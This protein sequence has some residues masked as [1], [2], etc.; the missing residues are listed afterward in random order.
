MKGFV[1]GVSVGLGLLAAAVGSAAGQAVNACYVPSVGAIYV[2]GLPGAPTACLSPSHT[3]IALGG[4]GMGLPDGSVTTAKLADGAVTT[5]KIAAN[6]VGAGQLATGAV[7]T[8]QLAPAAV[9]SAQLATNAVTSTHLAAGSVDSAQLATGAVSSS[10]LATGAVANADL[11]NNA[12]TVTKIANGAVSQAKLATPVTMATASVGVAGPQTT[13]LTTL[14][15]VTIT[16][17]GPGAVLVI[18]TGYAVQNEAGA[19][20]TVGLGSTATTREYATVTVGGLGANSGEI[21]AFTVMAV[22]PFATG[23]A[24]TIYATGQGFNV[25]NALFLQNEE[26]V[27][28]YF[29]S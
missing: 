23:G 9:T 29:P 8:A 22:V 10:H 27:A 1:R 4:A 21:N 3:P 18:L 7:T 19:S 13:T 2:V 5:L 25:T 11:A 15:S 6:A 17:P 14:G 12:V 26:I 24:K 16:L 20:A 28:L